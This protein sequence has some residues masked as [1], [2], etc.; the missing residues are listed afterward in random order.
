MPISAAVNISGKPK[1]TWILDK[2]SSKA[3]DMVPI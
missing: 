1:R 3:R 2:D